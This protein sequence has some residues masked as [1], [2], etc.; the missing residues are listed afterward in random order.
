MVTQASARFPHNPRLARV[1]D[2]TLLGVGLCV[3]IAIPKSIAGDARLRFE[4]LDTLMKAGHLVSPKYSTVGPLLSAPL[5]LLGHAWGQAKR[6]TAFYNTV[7]FLAWLPVVWREFRDELAPRVRRLV[8]LLLVFASMFMHHTQRYYGEVFTTLLVA[9]GV[10]ALSRGH[11]KRGWAAIVLG[12]L[13]TPACLLGL[14]GIAVCHARRL[15]SWLPLCGPLIAFALM[16]LESFLVRGSWF[17]TGYNY[18]AG[19]RNALPYA[20]LPNFSYPF[21]FGLLSILFSF[22]KGLVFFVPGLFLPLPKSA[23]ARFRWVH[24]TLVVY[25][26]GLVLTY[27]K[28]WSWYGGW[29]WGPR[30]FLAASIPA[31]LSLATNLVDGAACSVTRRTVV[32]TALLLSCWVGANGLAFQGTGLSLCTAN[33]FALAEYC[34]YVPEMSV[35]WHPFVD[36]GASIPAPLRPLS[37]IA[38]G[39]WALVAAWVGRELFTDLAR[40]AARRVLSWQTWW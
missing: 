5:Y 37:F 27:A 25:V 14:V 31:S 1:V 21:F 18:D 26:C 13:N 10:F 19:F 16:R 11:A 15:R 39:F 36:G 35:L 40:R 28:W 24:T 12:A 22:G 17:D 30:F 6:C 7:L 29:F 34:Y 2:W 9:V 32:A 8:L 4:A 38:V 33:Y 20:G 3:M 23:P